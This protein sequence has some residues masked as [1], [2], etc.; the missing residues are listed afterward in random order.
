MRTPTTL[1]EMAILI[2]ELR[3]RS[4]FD[5]D[6]PAPRGANAEQFYLLAISSLETAER[7][8]TLAAIN[9]EKGQ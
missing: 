2:K 6:M 3:N 9:E 4:L 7:F 8:A 1:M 5:G